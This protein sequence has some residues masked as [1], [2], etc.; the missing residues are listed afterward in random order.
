MQAVMAKV[1]LA[2]IIAVVISVYLRVQLVS[3]HPAASGQSAGAVPAQVVVVLRPSSNYRPAQIAARLAVRYGLDIH[4]QW[5]ITSLNRAC[6]V[7]DTA[8]GNEL[9]YKIQ[10][11]DADPLVESVQE[12]QNF[13]VAGTWEIDPYVNL[14]HSLVAARIDQS[15]QISTGKDVR[16][17]IID[18][19][20]DRSHV[21]LRGRVVAT[22][23]FV[24]A[25]QTIEI[26][27]FH[28]TAVAGIIGATARNGRGIVGVAPD[29]QLVSLRACWE[30]IPGTSRGRCNS[31]SLA[32]ALDWAISN[33]IKVVNMSLQ[34]RHDPL[35]ERLVLH[36]VREG[37]IVVAATDLDDGELSFPASMNEVIGVSYHDPFRTLDYTAHAGK[38][39]IAPGEE[40]LTTMPDN[41]YDFVSG[42]SFASAHVS[43]IVA[44]LV[45]HAPTIDAHTV[46][47][48][49][50]SSTR[51]SGWTVLIDACTALATITGADNCR[52]LPK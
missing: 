21:D 6:Y 22:L 17:A 45:E 51:I 48:V 44:L 31:F 3:P 41:T 13:F 26:V 36:A 35:V 30:S 16:V 19:G 50:R 7:F 39:F 15:H 49:L 4:D 18:T 24:D 23:N 25:D 10:R 2:V 20:L 9:K 1:T 12:M 52:S 14:Q 40:I 5:H 37:L 28:A 29:S 42:S 33:E 47:A 27:E 46:K 8:A 43:G 38:V 32:R 11:L 34:G